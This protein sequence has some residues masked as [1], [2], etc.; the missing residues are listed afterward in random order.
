MLP[1]HDDASAAPR[2]TFLRIGETIYDA[3]RW[4]NYILVFFAAS[5]SCTVTLKV[6]DIQILECIFAADF[7]LLALLCVSHGMRLSVFRPFLTIARS[8]GIFLVLAFVLSLFSLQQNFFN[9]GG[10]K[11]PIVVT[12]ARMAEL[13][14]D[15]FYM[16]Y[17]AV[18]YREDE[19]LCLFGAKVYYWTGIAGCVYS[20][21][22]LPLNLLAATQLGTY[23][24]HHRFRGFN[25]EGGG[26]GVYLLSVIVL[27]CVMRR[28]GWLSRVQFRTGMAVLGVGFFGS[29]SKSAYFALLALG[30][31][32]LAWF[33]DGW[34]RWAVFGGLVATLMAM[35]SVI[36]IQE[37]IEQ[38]R[39]GAEQ[40]QTLSNLRAHDGN[41]VMGRVAGAVLAPRMIAARPLLGIGWGNYPLVRDDAVYR[42][43]TAFS[44]ASVDAPNLGV[45]DYIVELGFPL[46]MYLVWIEL[47]PVLMLRRRGVDAWLIAL[48]LIQPVSNWT[49][50]HL[51]LM[52]PWVV[53]A[54][55]LG[56]GY[57]AQRS[58]TAG[59]TPA[60]SAAI[61]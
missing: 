40:Y 29:Q 15:A 52:H 38:Y 41:F 10:L 27:A 57:G 16:L 18:L 19:K 4:R 43:G 61:P 13:F 11:A 56:L 21:A 26:F 32:G 37:Q 47:K 5:L 34:R 2:T 33:L 46:W 49:G 24:D 22:T 60:L 36:G 35:G 44:I 20:F 25:N 59:G 58:E 6:G 54:F 14:L 50:A 23:G 7:L 17:L 3:G 31:I 12:V 8:Y 53:V 48:A 45:I 39:R 55:A 51:N 42:Q 1:A 30:V 9:N 28:R